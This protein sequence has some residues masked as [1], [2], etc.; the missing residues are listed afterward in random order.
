M[1]I[2]ATPPTIAAGGALLLGWL[3]RQK[4]TQ[5]HVDVNSRI[6]QLLK[7]TK[8]SSYAEGIKDQK[9]NGS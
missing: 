7:L 8:K 4:L 3:N 9:D 2:A 5:I 1:I 6:T